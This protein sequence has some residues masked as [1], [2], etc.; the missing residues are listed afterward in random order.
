MVVAATVR[1]E[2]RLRT[3]GTWGSGRIGL[4]GLVRGSDGGD[5]RVMV[6]GLAALR[7]ECSIGRG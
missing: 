3:E 2:A 7:V 4:G 1:E 6:D 5:D